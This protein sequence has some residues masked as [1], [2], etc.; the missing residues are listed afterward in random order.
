MDPAAIFI[1]QLLS[2]HPFPKTVHQAACAISSCARGLSHSLQPVTTSDP[3]NGPQGAPPAQ[4]PPNSH[5][6][7]A[8]HAHLLS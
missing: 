2:F 7:G 1:L 4:A 3:N 5:P 6:P 8:P